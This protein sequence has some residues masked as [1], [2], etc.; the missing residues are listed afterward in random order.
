M[1]LVPSAVEPGQAARGPGMRASRRWAPWLVLALYL[2]GAVAVTWRL[3]ASP[4][5]RMQVG[6]PTDVDLFAWFIRYS[7]ESVAHGSLPSLVTTAMNAPRGINLMWNTSLLLPGVLLTPVTLLAGPQVSLTV[8]LTL[9]FAGSAATMFWVLRRWSVRTWPAALGGAVY[10]FSPALAASGLGHYHVQF[11]VLP[12]LMIDALL[13]ILTGR[14]RPVRTGA[15]LGLLAAVQLFTGE[16]LLLDTAVAGLV[17]AV[18]L[19][20]VTA[21]EVP[22]RA[23]AAAAGLGSAAVVTLVLAG[24]GLWV[25]FHG[26]LTE[27]GSPWKV[28][29]FRNHAAAFVTPGSNLLLHTRADAAASA[30]HPAYIVEYVAYLGWPLLVVLLAAT[31]WYWADRRV[32]VAALSC[33]VLEILSLGTVQV[34]RGLAVPAALLPWR[35]LSHLPV[36]S[37][38]LPDRLSILA[39]GLA[40]AVLAVALD[41]ACASPGRR[42]PAPLLPRGTTPG[43]PGP[44]SPLRAERWQAAPNWR[45]AIPVAIAIVAVA[46]LIPR[47]Y[48]VT[49]IS[50][51]PT[52]YQAAFSRLRLPTDARVLVLPLP[53]GHRSL[54]LR[55]Y[56][57]TGQP[58]SMNGGYFI[59]PEPDGQARSY[60]G[61]ALQHFAI[62]IDSLW[63]TS[64][65]PRGQAAQP[66]VPAPA[67]AELRSWVARWRPAAVVAVTRRTS[68]LGRLLSTVFGPPDFAVGRVLGWR[69]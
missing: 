44:R 35:W 9:G 49:S 28:T 10:G 29:H 54:P 11:A 34:V 5:S 3:W 37:Q 19:A 69:R 40:A 61:P 33:A 21:R 6:D 24:Y 32:R 23:V 4:A 67:P 1:G 25:Q 56:A 51:A 27:H 13:R 68:R 18:V 38:V 42:P 59:G 7:A 31:I 20:L 65:P 58:G 14:G 46:P 66:P 26:P 16:E 50:P 43:A 39:D 60:G 15:W 52:G 62:S 22:G 8:L 17:I 57:E 48:Q 64:A 2:A 36:L 53:Y 45:P 55:W 30:A 47:P 41:L 63:G 12:P